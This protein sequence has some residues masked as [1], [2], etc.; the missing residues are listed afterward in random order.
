MPERAWPT[1]WFWM[2][3]S[4]QI[5]AL[6]EE[7]N[8]LFLLHTKFPVSLLDA[9]VKVIESCRTSIVVGGDPSVLKQMLSNPRGPYSTASS[10]LYCVLGRR[11]SKIAHI[12]SQNMTS[13]LWLCF[14]E[15]ERR[16]CDSRTVIGARVRCRAVPL[17]SPPHP[18]DAEKRSPPR[19]QGKTIHSENFTSGWHPPFP[20]W[21]EEREGARAA[22]R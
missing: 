9:C 21:R 10:R 20:P 5:I 14:T 17:P 12:V 19:A 11:V 8:G 2:S 4:F 13:C 15:T 22:R 7:V 1:V 3:D 6:S 16:A 18:T